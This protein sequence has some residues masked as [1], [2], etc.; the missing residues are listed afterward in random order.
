LGSALSDVAGAVVERERAVGDRHTCHSY[1]CRRFTH[2][3]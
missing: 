2:L 1:E 3:C